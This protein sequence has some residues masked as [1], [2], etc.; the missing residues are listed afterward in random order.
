M[1]DVVKN[2]PFYMKHHYKA[3]ASAINDLMNEKG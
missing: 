2:D 1:Y 3:S